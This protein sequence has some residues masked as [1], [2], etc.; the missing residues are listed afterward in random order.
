MFRLGIQ[1]HEHPSPALAI[2]LVIFPQDWG[3]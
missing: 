3:G 1:M 2:H